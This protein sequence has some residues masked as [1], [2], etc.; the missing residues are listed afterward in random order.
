[1]IETLRT[2]L[3]RLFELD[4]LLTL[5]Q[6]QLGF[7]PESVGGTG[8]TASFVRSLTEHCLEH[9]AIE[10]LVDAVVT[11]QPDA[12]PEL[13]RIRQFGIGEPPDFPAGATIADLSV[14]K[15]LESTRVGTVYLARREGTQRRVLVL[16]SELVHNR[17]GLYRFLVNTRLVSR[18]SHEGLPQGVELGEIDG[19]VYVAQEHVEGQSL[20]AR[21]A[22]SGPMHI[23][24]ARPILT[25]ILDALQELH[26]QQIVFAGLSPDDVLLWRDASGNPLIRLL[27]PA[28]VLLEGRPI[29]GTTHLPW[30][31]ANPHTMA[32]EL[33]QGELP[34]P[35]SDMY[36]FGALL[37]EVLTGT[38]L[39]GQGDA[40]QIAAS[41]LASD[42][43]APSQVA[44]RGWVPRE[45]DDFVLGLLAKQPDKRPGG[46]TEIL[47]QLAK[48]G[49]ADSAPSE[50]I[51]DEDFEA[52]VAAVAAA[53]HDP[54]LAQ[55]LEATV[56][57]G[58]DAVRVAE[59]F[60]VAAETLELDDVAQLLT[61]R[62][63]L[64]TR[65]A[66][67][68]EAAMEDSLAEQTYI[69][70]L[71]VD[72][73]HQ[74][75]RA[76]LETLRR[77]SGRYEELVEMLLERSESAEA[78]AD[79][80]KAMG[81][82]GEL[83]ARELDDKDQ[84]IVAFTQAFCEDPT[85][86]SYSRELERLAG[87][88]EAS[89]EEILSTCMQATQD[90][91]LADPAK[92][93][94]Y[95][96]MADW[97]L[98]KLKRADLA[99]PVYQAV[100]QVE[101]SN[102]EAL[103]G[104]TDIYRKAQQ[105]NELGLLL[106]TRADATSSYD[107]ARNLRCEAADI[108][109]VQLG[110]VGRARDLYE[111]ILRQDPGHERASEAL[112][113]IYSRTGDHQGEVKILQARA[114]TEHGERRNRTLCRIAELYET[115]LSNDA[116]AIALYSKVVED[117]P[118]HVDALRGLDRM[119][120]R[121]GRYQDLLANLAQQLDLA[122]TPRQRI[123]L[124]ERIAGIYDEEFLDHERAAESWEAILEIDN[125]NENALASLPRHYRSLERWEDLAKLYEHHVGLT[126]DP[127]RSLELHLARGR[128][129][130]EQL[131]SPDRAMTAYEAA[132]A[133]DPSHAGA[134]EALARL[135][136][137]TGDAEAA[138]HAIE[139]LAER[140]TTPEGKAEHYFRAARIKQ[141]RGDQDG[142]IDFYKRCLDLVPNDAT[143]SQALRAA[144]VARG[145][146]NAAIQLL[147][148]EFERQEGEAT[149]GRLAAE[150]AVLCRE[151]LHDS[152]RAE[153]A[154]K[155][156]L[157]F[158]PTNA[159]ARI[160]LGDLAF[161]DE[162]YLEASRHYEVVADRTDTLEQVRAIRLLL[163]YADALSKTGSTEKA[164]AP[165]DT[166]LRLAP[167]DREA[168]ERV[169]QVTF[170]HGAPKRAAELY[171]DLF[172]RFGEDMAQN[173]D[174]LYRY[175]ESL[176]QAG[177]LNAAI[178]PLE[179]ASDIDPGNAEPLIALARVFEDQEDWDR[180]VRT[181]TR[182]LDI[183]D[184]A[185]RVRL[186]IE[187]GEIAGDKL[188]DR[189]RAAKSFVAAL[190]ERPDDRRLLTK[191]MQLYSEEQDWE[192]LVDVVVKLA[193]FVDDLG[194]KAKYLQTAAMVTSRQMGDLDRALEFHRQVIDLDPNNEKSLNEAID[195]ERANARFE[196]VEDLLR[197][198]LQL[199]T[200]A[201]DQEKMLVQFQALAELYENDLAWIEKAIDA[202]EA[203]QTLDPSNTERAEKL[204]E[205]YASD[206]EKYLDKAVESQLAALRQNP[207][208]A[209]PYKLLRRLYTE[210][211]QADAAWALC[212]ALVVMNLA[213]PDEERFYRRMRAE[214][215]A[216]ARAAM[217][218][219]DWLRCVMSED[220]SPLLTSVFALIE[221]AVIGNRSRSLADLGYDGQY[222]VDLAQ[223]PYPMS[224]NL[225]YAAGV[226]GLEPPPTYQ[227]PNDPAGLSFLHAHTPSVV[228]GRAAMATEI[229]PQA[230]AFIAAR[231]LAYFR[232]GL[233][234]RQLVPTGTGLKAWLFAAMKLISPQFPI[235]PDIEGPVR[236][237]LTA[238]EAGVTGQARD[239]LAR[240]VSQLIQSGGALDL[241]R[242]VAGVDLTAD[243]AGLVVCHD[244]ETAFEI[245]KA[246]DE[247]ASAVSQDE[248]LK[249]LVLYSVS[250]PFFALRR[251]LGIAVDS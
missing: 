193:D 170:D 133:L 25:A 149:K 66:R 81:E 74:E 205:L 49:L 185:E 173:A 196:E 178:G 147:E 199:A 95:L 2:E 60:R 79:R 28:T 109:D 59:A 50:Q 22:R 138:I 1:M 158:D 176:R 113:R 208:R 186:L 228:L 19:Q 226:M 212:Q 227:N 12:R 143:T 37:Y 218:D 8:A 177:E 232:P 75:A 35:A 247:T 100:L 53:P 6:D 44:P 164:L 20:A 241:K 69:S 206:P 182:H 194:Q 130:S 191:L 240:V 105:W 251:Q 40:M 102:S 17:R 187:I 236:D 61:A 165:M 83:Y 224:Q 104:L 161:E 123:L 82:I 157:T 221:P 207:Y 24:E 87:S 159:D 34:T 136:E 235:G 78:G 166:L 150:V 54:Q 63:V 114:D 92:N 30:T 233:Y 57:L 155:R 41:Q 16:R 72:S 132:I 160:V 139:A 46:A 118:D 230:A 13:S 183:A 202:Y 153:E 234:V 38:P 222:Q 23:N 243:R 85:V 101:P 174:A 9:D 184:G 121:T 244:L 126:E 112:G 181:K 7:D 172:E 55:A 116:E 125:T 73:E 84:A 189:T 122:E 203:A 36:A 107:E 42:P 10:A 129:L 217:T 51:S 21:I 90:E 52:Q 110:D 134:L 246:S 124:W 94:I 188:A 39:F 141:D 56:D 171:Q 211:K 135:R 111:Q 219:D 71:A 239:H 29:P 242:W 223:H 4:E 108:L 58:V 142:A 14:A 106:T 45:L 204:A 88:D 190:E 201:E 128:V 5:C 119:Y 43:L 192:K 175:G 144:Y 140:A 248:R 62:V 214:T 146:V 91:S 47:L 163:R 11:L 48:A 27:T 115:H 96:Q 238:L 31:P 225:Y 117:D 15:T 200:Q 80:A 197:R 64:L 120:A 213:E 98:Y 89:W 97:Y 250:E 245:I 137:S 151:G 229:P 209:E 131:Q 67:M 93:Q 152:A 168:L 3:E 18:V 33:L 167:D 179:D 220:C 26:D 154:A 215:A 249:Q 231:H 99:L 148:R 169:A 103:R 86:P 237:A 210:T 32:P 77:R 156:S 162:R 65:S 180:V 76:A 145:D 127:Q 198:K 70:I 216:A 195:I 68:Y